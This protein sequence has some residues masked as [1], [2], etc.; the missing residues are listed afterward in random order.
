MLLP[1]CR[2]IFED[3]QQSTFFNF[4]SLCSKWYVFSKRHGFNSFNV[5]RVSKLF[6]FYKTLNRFISI[7]RSHESKVFVLSTF[8]IRSY[9]CSTSTAFIMYRSFSFL[10]T[11]AGWSWAFKWFCYCIPFAI[12]FQSATLKTC[13]LNDPMAKLCCQSSESSFTSLEL[14]EDELRSSR[15]SAALVTK[16][17]LSLNLLAFSKKSIVSWWRLLSWLWRGIES[18]VFNQSSSWIFCVR[19][20]L[21]AGCELPLIQLNLHFARCLTRLYLESFAY[22]GT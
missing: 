1:P 3:F 2:R 17:S 8:A 21:S 10:P 18:N 5:T 15:H 4:Q 20:D 6:E 13:F 22:W 9:I 16:H 19:T 7:L 11:S 14:Q 12:L